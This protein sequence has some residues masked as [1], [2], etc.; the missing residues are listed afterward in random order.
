[1]GLFVFHKV[2]KQ[3]RDSC[4][5]LQ[6]HSSSLPLEL[7]HP[8][9]TDEF[10]SSWSAKWKILCNTFPSNLVT[11]SRCIPIWLSKRCIGILFCT[12]QPLILFTQSHCS[13]FVTCTAYLFT[14][15][16]GCPKTQPRNLHFLS[17]KNSVFWGLFHHQSKLHN[18]YVCLYIWKFMEAN[19]HSHSVLCVDVGIL[20]WR[21]AGHPEENQKTFFIWRRFSLMLIF[22][23]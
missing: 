21:Q 3:S 2:R 17:F 12:L 9:R 7:S 23:A 11:T 6:S 13:H 8:L 15:K 22:M 18:R 4:T 16:D 1:M 14:L 19:F 20:E 10:S 5:S